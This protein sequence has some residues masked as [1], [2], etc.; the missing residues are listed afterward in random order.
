MFSIFGDL[1]IVGSPFRKL[2]AP[3]N[4]GRFVGKIC[5]PSQPEAHRPP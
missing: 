3:V 2:T 1:C 5:I 4:D